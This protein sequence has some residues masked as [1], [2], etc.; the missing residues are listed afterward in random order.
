M[1]TLN[2]G[3]SGYVCARV[4]MPLVRRF[5]PLA[6]R[7]VAWALFLGAMLPDLDALTAW[8][9]RSS[10]FSDGWYGHRQAS[11]SLLGTLLLALAAAASLR[12]WLAREGGARGARGLLWLAGCLWAG[13]LIHI[14]GDLFTPGMTM[15]LL[16]PAAPRVGAFSHIGWFSPY[17]LWMFLAA[18]AIE[19]L[20]RGWSR[21][22]P[23]LAPALGR[24][25][26]LL[27]VLVLGRWLHYLH[28]SRYASADQ[29]Q[30]YQLALLPEAMVTPFADVIRTLWYFLTR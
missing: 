23:R 19:A 29:W 17:L 5:S 21:A 4:A 14:V 26:W 11:H 16:W 7:A 27:Y 25:G 13:G 15:P 24:A 18:L 6:P 22:A 9:D 10:Y 12:P 8:V 3:F 1:M 30:E 2:H 20:L 28:V